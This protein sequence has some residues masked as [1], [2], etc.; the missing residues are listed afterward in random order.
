MNDLTKRDDKA[1][2]NERILIL[3]FFFF[4]KVWVQ[5]TYVV[6]LTGNLNLGIVWLAESLGTIGVG[7]LY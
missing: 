1:G 7:T 3:S 2:L 4:T 6:F 5:M